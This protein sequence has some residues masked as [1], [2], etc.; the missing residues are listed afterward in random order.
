MQEEMSS[1]V[2][3]TFSLSS[4]G[5]Q[6]VGCCFPHGWGGVS[7][8]LSYRN[9]LLDMPGPCFIVDSRSCQFGNQYNHLA[10]LVEHTQLHL[11]L[12]DIFQCGKL[13]QDQVQ[14]PSTSLSR[15]S[16]FQVCCSLHPFTGLVEMIQ[17]NYCSCWHLSLGF[18]NYSVVVLQDG[19]PCHSFS[20][21]LE[22]H[23]H[24]KYTLCCLNSCLCMFFSITL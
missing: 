7:S 8:Y 1:N 11:E 22:C 16:W 5:D 17:R 23:D 9:S 18:L 24:Q 14:S 12:M 2:Q 3:L 4:P 20:D 13:A 19:L 6:P 15:A 21:K 10:S